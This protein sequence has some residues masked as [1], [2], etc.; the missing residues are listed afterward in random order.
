MIKGLPT[1]VDPQV[2]STSGEEGSVVR[3]NSLNA[4][5]VNMD[6]G[7]VNTNNTWNRYYVA[8]ASELAEDIDGWFGAERNCWRNKRQKAEPNRIHYHL[9]ELYCFVNNVIANEYYPGASYCFVLSY[10]VFREVFAANYLDRIVHHYVAPM[11]IEVAEKVHNA[12]GNVSHGNREGH[13]AETA[14]LQIQDNIRRISGGG[15]RPCYVASMDV[16]GFFMSIDRRKAFSVFSMYADIHYTGILKRQKMALLYILL[17]CDPTDNCIRTCD[18]RLWEHVASNKSMFNNPPWIGMPIGNF[19]SQL[20]ANLLLA[21]L[22]HVIT[23]LCAWIGYTRFVDDMGFVAG[24]V[25]E[26]RRARV[27]VRKTLGALGLTLHPAKYYI[28]PSRH[29]LK[30]CGKVIHEDRMYITNRVAGALYRKVLTESESPSLESAKRLMASVNSY[31]GMMRKCAAYNIMMRISGMVLDKFGTWLFFAGK[32]GKL[33]CKLKRKYKEDYVSLCSI[34]TFVK[35][36][37]HLNYEVREKK[38]GRGAGNNGSG[39]RKGSVRAT[40]GA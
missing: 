15:R 21:I 3:N 33:T 34:N 19:Y 39:E 31:F 32:N 22:D 27:L 10:P 11:L 6:N 36:F 35:P 29:G 2:T 25:E 20:I 23:T 14:C 9:S 16:K 18:I 24:S 5:N 28:Q 30:F 4:W 17:S 40:L 37:K 26:I 7:N 8:L 38:R 13:S 1:C 12:N